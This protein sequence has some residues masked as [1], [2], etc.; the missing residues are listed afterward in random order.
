MILALSWNICISAALTFFT[1]LCTCVCIG[2]SS[3]AVSLVFLNH[4][5]PSSCTPF[6]VSLCSLFTHQ[7]RDQLNFKVVLGTTT[8][9][10]KFT[11]V[12]LNKCNPLVEQKARCCTSKG[13]RDEWHWCCR[14]HHV[15]KAAV[16]RVVFTAF[17]DMWHILTVC[18]T[19]QS[20][21]SHLL[22]VGNPQLKRSPG[23]T[24]L[25]AYVTSP[26]AAAASTQV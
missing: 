14:R 4:G 22:P 21:F 10:L 24:T 2:V 11:L 26:S 25:A 9:Q 1:V 17:P 12:Q 15:Q 13:F 19:C 6:Q 7:L 20:T 5:L 16:V 3:L 23:Q 8:W 18:D